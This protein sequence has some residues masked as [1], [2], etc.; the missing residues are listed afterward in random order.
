[1]PGQI[2]SAGVRENVAT[3]LSYSAAWLGGNGCIPLNHLMEDAATAEITRVQLWQWVKYGVRLADKG[4][5]VTAEYVDRLID[6]LAPAHPPREERGREARERDPADHHAG[7]LPEARLG[8]EED[9]AHDLRA[10]GARVSARA[11]TGGESD[12]AGLTGS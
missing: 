1:M 8:V 5:T 12:D 4:E 6:E 2:T 10:A 3:A 7:R 9:G 11:I